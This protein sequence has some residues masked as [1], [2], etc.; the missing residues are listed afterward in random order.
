MKK[1]LAWSV[2]S[3]FLLSPYGAF[4][5]SIPAPSSLGGASVTL[6]PPLPL[7]TGAA[8]SAL[9]TTGNTSLSTL[10]GTVSGSE[11]Q[12]DILSVVPGVGAV[13]LGKNHDNVQSAGHTG[14]F[15]LKVRKDTLNANAGVSQNGDYA[16]SFVD[17]FGSAWG[18][19]T[20]GAGNI[21]AQT[22]DVAH[23]TGDPGI[24]ALGVANN[25]VAELSVG[26]TRYT[27]VAVTTQGSTIGVIIN[28]T[29]VGG[30]RDVAKAEDDF[31]N[32]NGEAL[33]A[34][35]TLVDDVL[36]ANAGT[37]GDGSATYLRVDN[38]GAAWTHQREIGTNDFNI[39]RDNITTA[40]VNL[41]FG[42]TSNKIELRAPIGN[43]EDVCID[44]SGGT[45][46][47][48]AVNT[49][50]DY[51]LSPGE[52]LLLDD[53]AYS[54]ISVIAAASTQTINVSAWN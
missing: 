21:L 30:S 36:V 6:L 9:Q 40:S 16:A 54:S 31:I 29:N 5:Q 38:F 17:N 1:F 11:Q 8:T 50:G 13:N 4:A 48:P 37:S 14:V 33:L 47:C 10:A 35:A 24:M 3:L 27:P 19:P 45:A 23:I 32:S 51:R 15:I 53:A 49:A 41:A 42:F 44:F 34:I 7:P 20:D 2:L 22:E 46:V 52:T 18:T 26:N 28:S 25:T 43:G 39:N 12:V